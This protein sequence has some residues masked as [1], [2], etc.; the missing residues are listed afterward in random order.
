MTG[1]IFHPKVPGEVREILEYYD[2]ISPRLADEF[3]VELME[4]I[5]KAAEN[6]EAFH[7]DVH[8]RRRCNLKKFPYNF[9]YKVTDGGIRVTAVRHNKRDPKFGSR[10]Q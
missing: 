10:R 3:W 5:R 8:G 7:Y 2:E 6:P 9:L 1:V 4:G